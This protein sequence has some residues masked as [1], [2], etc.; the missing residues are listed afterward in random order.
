MDIIN[1]TT[2]K[3]TTTTTTTTTNIR[4]SSCSSSSSSVRGASRKNRVYIFREWL[5]RNYGS[6][7]YQQQ[8][9]QQQRNESSSHD[10]SD[11]GILILDVAGGKGD[12]SW[13]LNNVDGL[14]SI[15]LDPWKQQDGSTTRN[16]RM[17]KSIEFLCNNPDERS[18]RSVRGLS[19]YQPLAELIPKL[20]KQRL[21]RLLSNNNNNNNNNNNKSGENE[22]NNNN[23]I[24]SELP[25]SQRPVT[26]ESSSYGSTCSNSSTTESS[27][28][29]CVRPEDFVTPQLL[30]IPLNDEIVNQIRHRLII[31]K[32][33]KDGNDD[34]QKND[35]NNSIS[36]SIRRTDNNNNNNNTNN[37]EEDGDGVVDEDDKKMISIL[38][39]LSSGRIKLIV[40]FHPDQATE[41]CIDLA[42]I[43]NIPFCIVP[44]CV[45]PSE[46]PNR[47]LVLIEEEEEEQ[48]Q[49]QKQQQ[50]RN[51]NNNDKEYNNNNVVS[52]D[53]NSSNDKQ[54]QL[55]PV[56]TYNQF[57]KY[58][59][60]KP[61]TTTNE[62]SRNSNI[63]NKILT[64]YLDFHFTET[65]KNV[66]LYTLPPS[67]PTPEED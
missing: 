41:S 30:Q 17:V 44:C 47:R 6:Y 67:P 7:L 66:V 49:K 42:K 29:C 16:E 43:L 33:N 50:Q 64:A 56:R 51:N 62:A 10:D 34:E 26:P 40:G 32:K 22:Y 24:I 37:E 14:E 27:I 53:N 18:I 9:Q 45:F 19:T 25:V 46:F 59:R 1:E 21:K 38:N 57:L 31:C 2:T 8:Q 55:V 15:I 36:I 54:Q 5:I 61:T 28:S 52:N 35:N 63:N 4:T 39:I 12:L 13:L 11:D 60:Q 3:A 20:L 65:A 48:Q 58:L 23:Q